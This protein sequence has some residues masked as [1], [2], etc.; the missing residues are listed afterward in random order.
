MMRQDKGSTEEHQYLKLYKYFKDE[1]NPTLKIVYQAWPEKNHSPFIG[2]SVNELIYRELQDPTMK[3]LDL[4]STTMLKL[5]AASMARETEDRAIED[6]ALRKDIR[7]IKELLSNASS[8]SSQ[9]STSTSRSVDNAS[10][11]SL[12]YEI[13]ELKKSLAELT[14]K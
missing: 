9:T 5:F 13:G 8:G 2:K 12:K 4:D 7:E 1:R 3:D 14:D 6:M 10:M 11:G